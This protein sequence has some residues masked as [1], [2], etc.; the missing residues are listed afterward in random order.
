MARVVYFQISWAAWGNII[1]RFSSVR[2]ALFVAGMSV[3]AI[4]T[5]P[6]AHAERIISDYEAT[7]LTF[8]SL[9]A[10]PPVIHVRRKTHAVPGY[11]LA[12]TRHTSARNMV[13]LV[14]YPVKHN[15]V[16]VVRRHHT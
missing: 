6:S 2:C 15:R 4:T 10:P 12:S 5:G 14:S 11:R 13:H 9:T 1:M 16:H 7:K 8:A 3:C